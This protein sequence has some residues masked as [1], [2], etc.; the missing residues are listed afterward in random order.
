M[1]KFWSEDQVQY[2]TLD[3]EV[4][5]PGEDFYMT[6]AISDHAVDYVN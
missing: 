6:R 3:D 1:E 2:L 4:I 5:E